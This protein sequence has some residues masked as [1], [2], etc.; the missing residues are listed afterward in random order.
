MSSV[1]GLQ[2]HAGVTDYAASKAGIIGFTKSL[3]I[4]LAEYGV[5][6]NAISPGAVSQIVFDRG[7]TVNPSNVNCMRHSGKTDDV[8]GVVA[9]LLSDDAKYVTGQNIVVDGGRSLGLWGDGR[10]S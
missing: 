4:E 6:V 10:S 8:A 5:T 9:W 2:G 1:V 7:R 3:A